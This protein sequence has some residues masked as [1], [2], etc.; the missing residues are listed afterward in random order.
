MSIR[1]ESMQD[2]IYHHLSLEKKKDDLQELPEGFWDNAWQHYEVLRGQEEKQAE[3]GFLITNNTSKEML[4]LMR[5]LYYR[6]QKK[7]LQIARN[8]VVAPSN[9]YSI[10]NATEKEKQFFNAITKVLRGYVFGGDQ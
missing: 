7:L 10:G 4:K 8:S 9:I 5:D 2:R 3:A 1:I 6:R